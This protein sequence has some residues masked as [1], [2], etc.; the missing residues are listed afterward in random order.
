M[1]DCSAVAEA[2]HS[3]ACQGHQLPAES[4]LHSQAYR[5]RSAC[6]HQTTQA[7]MCSLGPPRL[8][9]V[10][11]RFASR[12]FVPCATLIS[13]ETSTSSGTKMSTKLA[14]CILES[15]PLLLRAPG[16]RHRS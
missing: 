11:E 10:Q 8:R 15:L 12:P 4:W 14:T 16:V 3:V 7:K 2:G 6:N 1:Q 5:Y 13:R 9:I